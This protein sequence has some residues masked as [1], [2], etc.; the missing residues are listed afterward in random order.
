S[1]SSPCL[2]L[3]DNHI[4]DAANWTAPGCPFHND[5]LHTFG[6]AGS[7]M[8]GLYVSN[9]LFDGDW[10]TCPTGFIFIEGGT[11][12]PSHL[13]SSYFWNNVFLVQSTAFENTNGWVG[14]FSGDSGVQQFVNNTIVYPGPSDNTSCFSFERLS[15]LTVA[16]N[17]ASGC[18]N[19]MSVNNSIVTGFD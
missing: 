8:D 16:N 15:L 2:S 9:N 19:P 3:H 6:F 12:T 11:S 7:S 1:C 17:A 5:G 18:G 10:G 13:R 4:H 14:I